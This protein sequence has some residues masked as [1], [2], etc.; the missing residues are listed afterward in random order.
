VRLGT[1]RELKQTCIARV[2]CVG[3]LALKRQFRRA[4]SAKA[5]GLFALRSRWGEVDRLPQCLEKRFVIC[6]VF[7]CD[8]ESR[9]MVN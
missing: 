2:C 1:G 3:S 8:V 7:A 5:L 4:L 9:P 6:Y